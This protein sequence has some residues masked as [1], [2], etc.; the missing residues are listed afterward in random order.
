MKEAGGKRAGDQRVRMTRMLIRKAFTELLNRKPIQSISVKELCELAGINRGTFYAH[1]TDTY[2]LLAGLEEEMLEDFKKA[3]GPLLEAEGA[4]LTPLKVT[5]GIFRC[6]KDNA[7][8]CTVTL[9]PY[10][11]KEF[12]T[13]LLQIGRERCMESYSAFFAGAS[14]RNLEFFYAFVSAG[15]IGVLEKWL[16]EGMSTEI[17]ELARISEGIMLQ[18][19]RFLGGRDE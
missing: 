2:D 19:I 17:D 1:Y 9:G 12:A 16:A 14:R 13:R 8:L 6:L 3:L 4:D 18:G 15:Y 11:D 7:D 5:A 10:G